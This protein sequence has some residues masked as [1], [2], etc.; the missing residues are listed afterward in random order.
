MAKQDR[1][2]RRQGARGV[3][4]G[5]PGRSQKQRTQTKALPPR[6]RQ[7]RFLSQPTSSEARKE[8]GVEPCHM[9]SGCGQAHR[10]SLQRTPISPL[11]GVPG[12]DKPH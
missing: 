8:D 3:D 12:N 4:R 1:C 5:A 7:E 11:P 10:A 6:R 2:R 9:V